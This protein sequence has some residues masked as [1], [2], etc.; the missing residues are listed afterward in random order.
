MK[1][2]KYFVLN[3][4]TDV[5]KGYTEV[6]KEYVQK[7]IKSFLPGDRAYFI[8]LGYAIMET[9][10][11]EYRK[12]YHEKNVRDY[13]KKEAIRVGEFSYDAIN[14]PEFEESGNRELMDASD[15]SFEDKMAYKILAEKLPEALLELDDDEAAL[16]EEIFF[17]N[18]SERELAAKYGVSHTA[19]QKRRKKILKKL[20][21]FF[22]I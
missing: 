9:N 13:Q 4:R 5:N 8:N 10:M 2:K 16:I 17:K 20:E 3:D 15:E 1:E 22:N 6:S 21:K 18:I 11:E 7:Y 12:Y 14:N 19:I